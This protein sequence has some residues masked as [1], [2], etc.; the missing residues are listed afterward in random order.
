MQERLELLFATFLKLGSVAKVMR[1]VQRPRPRSAAAR[2]SWRSRWAGRRLPRSQR[3]LKNPA[4]AGAFVYGR[5]RLRPAQRER[6]TAGEGAEADR[7][8][9]D[10]RQ[11]PLPGLYRLANL[12]EDQRHDAAT[13]G[14]NTCARRPGALRAM[15]NCCCTASSGAPDAAT[16][17]TSATKAAA[18]YVCNHLRSHQGLPACQYLRR[19]AYRC[20]R[21]RKRS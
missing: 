18:K 6:P 3:C 20:C 4:Y 2:S 19:A 12:R 13:T 1:R 8:M 15:A 16:R 21:A 7:G 9:A 5:T 10:R 11:G 14:P 17:C